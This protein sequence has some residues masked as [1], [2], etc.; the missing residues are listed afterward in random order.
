MRSGA[1]RRRDARPG[2]RGI[3]RGPTAW[4]GLSLHLRRHPDATLKV[5]REAPT[6]RWGRDQRTTLWRH[7]LRIDITLNERTYA[8]RRSS[9]P[10]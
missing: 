5:L 9:E 4:G 6:T 7:L 10:T 2:A 3:G 1:C 8:R